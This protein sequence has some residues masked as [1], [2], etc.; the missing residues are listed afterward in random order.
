MVGSANIDLIARVP[1]LP[2]PGET[3]IGSQFKMGFGGKGANQAVM[4]ARLGAT[5]SV[6]CKVGNDIFGQDTL[7]NFKDQGIDT[8]HVLFD[9]TRFS[10]VAPITVDQHTGQNSIIIVPGANDGL[11]PSD[12]RAAQET[13][14][15]AQML[16]CQLEIPLETT[17]EAFRIAKAAPSPVMTLLNPAPAAPLPDELLRLTDI[18]VPNET[19]TA[20]LTGLPVES[21]EETER[22]ARVLQARGVRIVVLTLGARGA[23]CIEGDSPEILITAERVDAVDTSGAG[24]SFIGSFAYFYAKGASVG[25]A[26]SKACRIATRSVLKAG[27]QTSFPY[28]A[29]LVG[30]V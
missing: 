10:G 2:A 12:V 29:E 1:R 24:D 13:I 16:L 4:A 14:Y 23:L 17:L 20:F 21:M 6:V 5:V 25:E 18:L 3:L 7:K 27:T 30:I 8:Q 9:E 26:A 28:P 15:A 19:E 11:S 22:A